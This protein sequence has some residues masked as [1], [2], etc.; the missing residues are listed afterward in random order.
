MRV[1]LDH[2]LSGEG[3]I[4]ISYPSVPFVFLIMNMYNVYTYIERGGEQ[5]KME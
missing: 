1:Q 5:I 2:I 4:F 3:L